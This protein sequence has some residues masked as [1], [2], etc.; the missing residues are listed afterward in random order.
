M[1]YSLSQSWWHYLNLNMS[2]QQCHRIPVVAEQKAQPATL[3][4]FSQPTT[5]GK[6]VA[7]KPFRQH[8]VLL[9]RRTFGC[10][11][12]SEVSTENDSKHKPE[13]VIFAHQPPMQIEAS[14][15]DQSPP[16]TRTPSSPRPPVRRQ[17]SIYSF[18]SSKSNAQHPRTCTPELRRCAKMSASWHPPSSS[19]SARIA[20]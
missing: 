5:H 13:V 16:T 17:S 19:A 7:Q 9:S 10:A 20:R 3:P 4:D 18:P 6:A 14:Q 12:S 15:L 2:E 1:S 11:W 8:T